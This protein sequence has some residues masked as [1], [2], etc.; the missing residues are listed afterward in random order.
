MIVLIV[1]CFLPQKSLFAVLIALPDA[2]PPVLCLMSLN[3][4]GFLNLHK[5]AGLTSH[6]CVARVR[7]L[8]KLKRVGHG[9]TLDPAVSG[10]LPMAL[11]K[12]TRLLQFLRSGKTYR[13]TVRFG[14][15]TATDDL[16]GEILRSQSAAFLTLEA[17]QAVIPRFLGK[18]QQVPPSYSAIQ[19][20]G[21]RLYNLARQGERV[22]APPRTVEVFRLEIQDWRPGEFPE[23][24]LEIA[25]GAGTYIRALA[26]DLGEVLT[27]GG[28][29]AV[30][31][32]IESSGFNLADSV[33]FEELET[34][35]KEGTFCPI[36]PAA[37][38]A[39][40]PAAILPETAV[41]RWCQGQRIPKGQIQE[42]Q[43]F[44]APA[45]VEKLDAET[46]LRVY[47]ESGQFLGMGQLIT[48]AQEPLLA[49]QIVF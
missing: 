7:R 10:V 22:T 25:C 42:F 43:G 27:V 4:E 14:M 33:S 2:I 30:L 44:S 19:I 6:D 32:R 20:D 48:L 9:G 28:T 15:S 17:I 18:I 12:A 35:L 34:Q 31:T 29:L 26:R 8:L 45:G 21:K 37:V 13:G 40:L 11:G 38:L 24:D 23:L 1:F 41:K 39:H 49:P 47:S 16:E 46:A 3:F 5:P 36:S